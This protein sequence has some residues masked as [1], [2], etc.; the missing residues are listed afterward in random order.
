MNNSIV[1]S[2]SPISF[3]G[4]ASSIRQPAVVPPS[5]LCPSRRCSRE[6]GR[7]ARGLNKLAGKVS[8]SPKRG[9]RAVCQIGLHW[10][11]EEEEETSSLSLYFSLIP[12]SLFVSNV[13]TTGRPNLHIERIEIKGGD[14]RTSLA[15]SAE[16]EGNIVPSSL[17]RQIPLHHHPP[18][19]LVCPANLKSGQE[20]ELFSTFPLPPNIFSRYLTPPLFACIEPLPRQHRERFSR[21][22]REGGKE[23]GQMPPPTWKDRERDGG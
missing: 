7:E 9:G 5:L 10:A 23:E 21:E 19:A 1:L 22:G 15:F 8:S 14:R 6:G 12:S 2:S 3:H 18:E 13:G 20:R 16:T 4:T 17:Q 11:S